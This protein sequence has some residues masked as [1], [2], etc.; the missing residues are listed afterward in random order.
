MAFLLIV[1]CPSTTPSHE[2]S[3]TIALITADSHESTVRAV[4]GARK[5][6][7][8]SHADANFHEFHLE[9]DAAFDKEVVDSIRSIRPNVILTVG[10]S[11]TEFA[12]KYFEDIPIVFAAVKHPEL[13]G[14]VKSLK[15]PGNRIT[16]ASLNIPV[17]IQ[18]R[19]FK[20][21]IPD[22]QRLGVLYTDNTAALID[23][24]DRVARSVGVELTAIKIKSI[25][26]LNGALD[27][28]SRLC[29]GLWTVPDPTLFNAQS[30]RYILLNS[31]RRGLPVMGFSRYVVESGA[32][33]ALDFDYKAVGFQ[34]GEIVVRVLHGEKPANIPVSSVDLIWFHY[35]EKTAQHLNIQMP[36]DLVAIAKE[37]YR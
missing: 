6:T 16:G 13:S 1:L 28:L 5:V 29:D 8:N 36:Q 21:V 30:T 32:L 10:S 9:R 22:L 14:Y 25:R 27:S 26:E 2:A 33:F 4:Y 20:T 12:L 24:A 18:F 23:H 37:V 17:D 11:A 34:A 35:N 31:I 7:L 3:V 15:R 19:Y